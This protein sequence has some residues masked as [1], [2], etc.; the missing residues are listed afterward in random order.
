MKSNL[1]IP[2][3]LPQALRGLAAAALAGVLML[4]AGP[5]AALRESATASGWRFVHGGVGVDEIKA[6]AGVR[7]GYSFWVVTA[8]KG[9]GAYLADV[10]VRIRDVGQRLVFEAQLD[11]PWLLVDLPVGRYTV[12]ASYAGETH[13]RTTTIH[14][15]DRHQ[16]VFYFNV[17]GN[18]PPRDER[19]S[20]ED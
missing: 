12:E 17:E 10:T 4:A 18:V 8:V 3:A 5:A 13:V 14:A 1:G 15:G 11:G 7:A 20:V 9:S 2:Q 16:A 19:S 6:L